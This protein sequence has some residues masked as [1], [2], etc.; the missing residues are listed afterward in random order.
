MTFFVE[1]KIFLRLICCD[2]FLQ[3]ENQAIIGSYFFAY[4]KTKML[5]VKSLHAHTLHCFTSA[6][7]APYLLSETMIHGFRVFVKGK[8]K[9]K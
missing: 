1:V 8:M 6:L 4:F 7:G 2:V 3:H 9:K 5:F